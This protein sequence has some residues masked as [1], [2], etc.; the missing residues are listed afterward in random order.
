[1]ANTPTVSTSA[2]EDSAVIDSTAASKEQEEAK[3][4]IEQ[5]LPIRM[6]SKV[7]R[8]FGRGS[9]DLGIPTAN[10]D[11]ES[12]KMQGAAGQEEPSFEDLPCGIYFGFCRIGESDQPATAGTGG[13][14]Y[15]AALSIGYNPTYGNGK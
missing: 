1:M 8:G 10:L 14:V 15:K 5:R 3:N 4:M 6:M 11:R 7:V 9:A 12:L 2:L 13:V